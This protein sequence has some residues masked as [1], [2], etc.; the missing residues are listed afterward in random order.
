MIDKNHEHGVFP[1]IGEMGGNFNFPIV[2]VDHFHFD[3]FRV[4]L[5]LPTG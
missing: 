3:R 2:S 4:G 5:T 1:F